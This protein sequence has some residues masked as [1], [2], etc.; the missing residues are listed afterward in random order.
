MAKEKQKPPTPAELALKDAQALL[1]I[2]L[3]IKAYFVK[4]ASDEPI[5][6]EDERTFLDLKSEVQRLQRLLRGKM[7]AGLTFGEQRMADLLRQSISIQHLRELPKMDRQLLV[8]SWHYVFIHLAKAVG[9]LQ[10]IAEGYRPSTAKEKTGGGPNI[11]ELKGGGG[12][13]KKKKKKE[14]PPVGK[15]ILVVVLLGAAIWVVGK[16]LNLF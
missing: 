3:R 10:F 2:W 9:A 1:E 16:R 14:K 5:T 11:S 15:Y 13:D 7:V 12:G 6:P 8:N 4:A